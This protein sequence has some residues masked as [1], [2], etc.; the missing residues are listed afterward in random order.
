MGRAGLFCVLLRR[1]GRRSAQAGGV[2][3]SLYVILRAGKDVHPDGSPGDLE[4]GRSSGRGS[5]GRTA[6]A[7]LGSC[8]AAAHLLQ[9][10]VPGDM[11]TLGSIATVA[12]AI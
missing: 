10:R 3:V 11:Y 8:G 12:I 7:A 6:A 5:P 2:F 1:S 9:R 4:P